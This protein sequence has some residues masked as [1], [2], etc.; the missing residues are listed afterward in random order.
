M[1]METRH[2]F[3]LSSTMMTIKDLRI[4]TVRQQDQDSLTAL[5]ET[6]F[7]DFGDYDERLRYWSAV[8]GVHTWV[9][10]VSGQL[11]GFVMGAFMANQASKTSRI[12]VIALCVDRSIRRRGV[13]RA[14]MATFFE[15]G[16]QYASMLSASE[17]SLDVAEDNLSGR[18]L[19]E[20]L[21]FQVRMK[22]SNQTEVR[23][24]M[25][26]AALEM[27]RPL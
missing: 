27:F 13:A 11:V 2:S 6:N 21:G 19:F 1:M 10:E 9:A 3:R 20:G 4:R 14:L 17:F 25:G 23:Y 18:A 15:W 8:N 22:E 24:P 12:Y 7:K 5:I 26:Q 16:N